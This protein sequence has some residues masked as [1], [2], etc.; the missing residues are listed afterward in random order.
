MNDRDE[1]LRKRQTE[2]EHRQDE[3]WDSGRRE[4]REWVEWCSDHGV[5]ADNATAAQRH[6]YRVER[7]WEVVQLAE[8]DLQKM[9]NDFAETMLRDGLDQETIVGLLLSMRHHNDPLCV[10][11]SEGEIAEVSATVDLSWAK[12]SW[13]LEEFRDD[14]E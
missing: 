5:D 14:D 13:L 1:R 8:W 11:F 2:A 9:E 3:C 6:R 10:G 4:R 12:I 7:G